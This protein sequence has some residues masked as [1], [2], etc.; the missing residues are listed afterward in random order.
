MKLESFSAIFILICGILG[1]ALSQVFP[2]SLL[3]YVVL[4]AT[5]TALYLVLVKKYL[6]D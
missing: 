3:L 4:S 5:A 6:K 2:D 1:Y